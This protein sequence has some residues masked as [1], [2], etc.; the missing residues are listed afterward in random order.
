MAELMRTSFS[1]VATG[2]IYLRPYSSWNT[3]SLL[4]SQS[5]TFPAKNPNNS[6]IMLVGQTTNYLKQVYVSKYAYLLLYVLY[7]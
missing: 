2:Y 6:H 3:D 7:Q 5:I 1:I 4:P